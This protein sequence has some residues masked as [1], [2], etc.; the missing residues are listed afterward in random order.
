MCAMTNGK[1][2]PAQAENGQNCGSLD[3]ARLLPREVKLASV[4][5]QTVVDI[6]G[7]PIRNPDPAAYLSSFW[8]PG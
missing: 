6:N 2:T 7:H 8:P 5:T 4:F 3:L 1:A